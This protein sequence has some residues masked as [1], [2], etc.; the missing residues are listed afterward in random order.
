MFPVAVSLELRSYLLDDQNVY[1]SVFT[2]LEKEWRP[3]A[4][5]TMC[6][7]DKKWQVLKPR[8]AVG[9]ARGRWLFDASVHE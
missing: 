3:N 6:K 8:S 9:V 2:N 7:M 5:F 1:H 4:W